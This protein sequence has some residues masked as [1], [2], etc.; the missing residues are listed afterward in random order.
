MKDFEL[1]VNNIKIEFDEVENNI[2]K[3]LQCDIYFKN[4]YLIYIDLFFITTI[5]NSLTTPLLK[6]FIIKSN[7]IKINN[8]PLIRIFIQKVIKE[9]N[10]ENKIKD[11]NIKNNFNNIPFQHINNIL[12][13]LL[14]FSIS[15]SFYKEQILYFISKNKNIKLEKKEKIYKKYHKYTFINI[16]N[17]ELLNDI[18]LNIFKIEEMNKLYLILEEYD[19]KIKEDIKKL[20]LNIVNYNI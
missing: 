1:F 2:E 6:N 20:F 11:L 19:I 17:N 8:N 15:Y 7:N 9:E 3:E 12:Q 18:D 16:E 5:F 4:E 10:D 14:K 13:N